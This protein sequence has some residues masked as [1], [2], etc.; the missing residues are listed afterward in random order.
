M[1]LAVGTM[2][3]GR[4]SDEPECRR[5]YSLAR[6]RGVRWF[7]SASSYSD[8]EAE[9]ILGRCI[10][11]D[12]RR[13]EV[14]ISTKGGYRGEDIAQELRGSL[15]RLGVE[16]VTL[17]L[18]HH[19]MRHGSQSVLD[20]LVLARES[21]AIVSYGL[22]NCSA[23]QA[24]EARPLWPRKFYVQILYSLAKRGAESEVLPWARARA[25]QVHVFAYSPLAAGLLTGK[26]GVPARD[27][28]GVRLDDDER[29]RLR[30]RHIDPYLPGPYY[31]AALAADMTPAQLAVAW[32]EAHPSGLVIPIIGARN[33]PQ[34]EELLCR[35]PITTE[36]WRAVAS[37]F[38]APQHPT[39]RPD[40]DEVAP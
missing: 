19:W 39:G 27:F 40:D 29:Y 2:T 31:R 38:P 8:G 36:Q 24:A 6:E 34:L 30:F 21:G 5:M 4:E 12:P 33:V 10:A 15:E 23:W 32:V 20:Q 26:Y 13:D 7:D 37:L 22:S 17:Y 25:G 9:R 14:L 35:K 11:A 3:W 16:R 18:H 1:T 28:G